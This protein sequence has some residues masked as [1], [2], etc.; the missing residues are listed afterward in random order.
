ME[1]ERRYR[2][3]GG[4]AAW[5][6][7]MM[8]GFLTAAAAVAGEWTIASVVVATGVV[9]QAIEQGAVFVISP[10]GLTRGFLIGSSFVGRPR[11]VAWA[12]I[13]EI[14]TSWRGERDYTA[15]ETT[16]RARDDGVLRFSSGMGLAAYQALLA[17]V[18]MRAPAGAVR[19]GL[20]QQVL[21]EAGRPSFRVSP[22][23]MTAFSVAIVL[24]LLALAA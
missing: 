16:V 8:F 19:S 7:P 17:E 22:A 21:N 1:R 18:S 3:V 14:A 20:T 5:R 15:L 13:T 10:R 12:S 24:A 9:A 2:V 23:W 11:I 6:I 4:V